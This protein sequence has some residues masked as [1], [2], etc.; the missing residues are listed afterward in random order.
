MQ[1]DSSYQRVDIGDVPRGCIGGTDHP[2]VG[3]VQCEYGCRSLVSVMY[4]KKDK[5][6]LDHP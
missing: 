6:T 5:N 3:F 2:S 1:R 4:R